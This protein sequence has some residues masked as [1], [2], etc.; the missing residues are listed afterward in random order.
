M[1]NI[2]NKTYDFLSK[3]QR[4][5]PALGAFYVLICEIWGTPFG[6]EVNRTITGFAALL[7]AYLEI[8]TSVYNSKVEM[9]RTDEP[10]EDVV[11]HEKHEEA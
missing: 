10:N 3:F 2:S 7:A 9:I 1:F 5:I 6:D 4:W 8:S 11:D